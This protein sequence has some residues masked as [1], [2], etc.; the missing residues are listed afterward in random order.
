MCIGQMGSYAGA[1]VPWYKCIPYEL[2]SYLF[3]E[4]YIGDYYRGH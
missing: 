1:L 2:W 3:K 4:G